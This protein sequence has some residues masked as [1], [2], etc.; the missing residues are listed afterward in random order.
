MKRISIIILCFL[1]I[2]GCSY[3]DVPMDTVIS[4][5]QQLLK[6]KGCNFTCE[7][8]ADYG[9][10]LYT[11]LLACS[12]DEYGNITFQVEAPDSIQGIQGRIDQDGGKLTFEDQVLAFP[13][14]AE[15]YLSPVSAPWVMI[16]S[17]RGGYIES[18]GTDES[19]HRVTIN[20]TYTDEAMQVDIWL[21][22]DNN[23]FF[24]QII[25]KGT[26]ILSMSVVDFHYL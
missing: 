10:T 16:K 4:L 5:R 17:L 25:W 19:G 23:P 13:L 26:R 24:C 11:F 3:I 22:D 21:D 2:T 6:S 18:C 14:L 15:G 1:L 9:D 7:I 12:S 8:T 20:D